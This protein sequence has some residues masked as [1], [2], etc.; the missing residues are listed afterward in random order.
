MKN[1]KL[2]SIGICLAISV[3]M[4]AFVGNTAHAIYD[5]PPVSSLLLA[6]MVSFTLGGSALFSNVMPKGAL[7]MSLN[8]M[9][10]TRKANQK[11]IGGIAQDHYYAFADDIKTYPVG[12]N[13]DFDDA[14]FTKFSDL[15]TL[16]STDVFVMQPGKYFYKLPCILEEGQLKS[17]QV[18]PLG[19]K[20]FENTGMLA[21][22]AN[23]DDFTGLCAYAANKPMIFLVKE[24]NGTYKVVGTQEYPA[25]VDA[26]ENTNGAKVSDGNIQK[27]TLKSY[28]C[29]PSPNYTGAV[30][31]EPA[32][33]VTP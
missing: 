19:S 3:F 2:Y 10:I 29:I 22:P 28:G 14:S 9:N 17:T 6:T 26:Y 5:L 30:P 15:V 1:S 25:Q 4:G 11:N 18:G 24:L 31:L 33:V 32:P 13:P 27:V 16:K 23:L 7:F 20:A 21:N 8:A 12:L